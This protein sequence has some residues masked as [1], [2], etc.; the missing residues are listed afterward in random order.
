MRNKVDRKLKDLK[1]SGHSRVYS[2][3]FL[4]VLVSVCLAFGAGCIFYAISYTASFSPELRPIVFT[5]GVV[6]LILL[7]SFGFIDPRSANSGFWPSLVSLVPNLFKWGISKTS[8]ALLLSIIAFATGAVFLWLGPFSVKSKSVLCGD[9]IKISVGSTESDC[10][11]STKIDWWE[12][13]F[14]SNENFALIC[15]DAQENRWSPTIKDGFV[16]SCGLRPV[17][18]KY[19]KNGINLYSN[20]SLNTVADLRQEQAHKR[21]RNGLLEANFPSRDSSDSFLFATWNLRNISLDSTQR[22]GKRLEEAYIFIAEIL[23]YF[24]IIAIQ[25]VHDLEAINKVLSYMNENYS[26]EFS[27][28]APGRYGNNE[29]Q[30]FIYDNRKIKPGSVS[31]TLVIENELLT[32]TGSGQPARPPFLMEFVINNRKIVVVN[33][34]IYFGSTGGIKYDYRQ[35]ELEAVSHGILK[36]KKSDFKEIPVIWAGDLNFTQANGKEHDIVKLAGFIAPA[37]L[38]SLDTSVG[39]LSRPYDQILTPLMDSNK[40]KFGAYGVF[41]PFE[42]VFRLQDYLHYKIDLA[43]LYDLNETSDNDLKKSYERLRTY[44]LSDHKIK[45]AEFRVDWE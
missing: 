16:N 44:Q 34:H 43:R 22:G 15:T 20:R 1:S 30:G 14:L 18:S 42:Y 40:L 29:R 27:L 32:K 11:L 35:K 24:D 7:L 38:V 2:H 33:S 6:F 5:M 21:L 17:N 25:E 37:T 10:A 23:S 39:K 36:T 45:W 26:S 4:R 9:A 19:V 41:D 13:P 31:T 3:P 12:N 8:H 28:V